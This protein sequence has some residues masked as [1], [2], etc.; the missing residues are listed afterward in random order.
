MPRMGG[1]EWSPRGLV[2]TRWAP[3][4]ELVGAQESRHLSGQFYVQHT[5]PYGTPSV[6]DE[7]WI[8]GAPRP[9]PEHPSLWPVPPDAIPW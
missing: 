5:A 9:R 8:D 6:L 3:L 2:G 4:G 7:H 1:A